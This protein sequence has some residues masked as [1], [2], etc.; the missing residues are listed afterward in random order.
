MR[1]IFFIITCS[2]TFLFSC[3]QSE[4]KQAQ[5]QVASYTEP[6]KTLDCRENYDSMLLIISNEFKPDS[7]DLNKSLSE[8]ASSFLLNVDTNCLR[9]QSMYDTFIAIILAK[10]Y[11][12]HLQC[13]NQGYDLLSMKEGAAKVIIDEFERLAGYD[14]KPT[15]EFLNSSKIVE[16]ISPKSDL[17]KNSQIQSLL[18]KINKEQKRIQK[19]VS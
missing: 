8:K 13:C 18:N 19:G 10:L 1:H 15:L 14:K 17:Q 3:S 2:L 11:Y 16:Y 4:Q 5:K 7:I 12:H 6:V 9:K